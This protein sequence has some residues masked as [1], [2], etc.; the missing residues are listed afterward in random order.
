MLFCAQNLNFPPSNLDQKLNI[1]CKF[2]QTV[3]TREINPA[4]LLVTSGI[5]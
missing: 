5:C 4:D 1:S 2:R 3:K